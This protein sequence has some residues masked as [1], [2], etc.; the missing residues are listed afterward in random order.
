MTGPPPGLQG[1]VGGGVVGVGGA[2]RET[3]ER[4]GR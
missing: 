4:E 1:R 2:A 3:A